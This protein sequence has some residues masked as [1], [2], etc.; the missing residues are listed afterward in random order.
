MTS[1]E[2]SLVASGAKLSCDTHRRMSDIQ[3]SAIG[4]LGGRDAMSAYDLAGALNYL[5][6]NSRP[7]PQS[8]LV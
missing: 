5:C 1:D 6:L 4:R 8:V 3:T 2:I 7:T